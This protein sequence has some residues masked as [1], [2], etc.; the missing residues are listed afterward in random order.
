MMAQL[1][2]QIEVVNKKISEVSAQASESQNSDV[3][4]QELKQMKDQLRM[5]E[6]ERKMTEV[7]IQ[8]CCRTNA[9]V[10]LVIENKVTDLMKQLQVN[11]ANNYVTEQEVNE[12]LSEL[13]SK[14]KEILFTYSSESKEET[15]LDK[16]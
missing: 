13:E 1:E 6:E 2:K 16:S 3:F 10:D 9:N 14:T 11:I 7:E 15:K 12:K 5:L 4:D 8:K